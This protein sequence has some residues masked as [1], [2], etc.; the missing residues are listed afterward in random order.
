MPLFR[1]C[2]SC[3]AVVQLL[4]RGRGGGL[5]LGERSAEAV[6]DLVE[7]TA[8]LQPISERLLGARQAT[9]KSEFVGW[10]R[11]WPKNCSCNPCR[12]VM[13]R[14]QPCREAPRTPREKNRLSAHKRR[15]KRCGYI[16]LPR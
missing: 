14:I 6:G 5:E 8:L 13:L 11:P 4:C 3:K 16:W 2:V 15:S 10:A 12:N 9:R 1:P 7:D